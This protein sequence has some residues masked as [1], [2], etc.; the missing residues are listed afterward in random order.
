MEIIEGGGGEK[1]QERRSKEEAMEKIDPREK[2]KKSHRENL[3]GMEVYR[4]RKEK[5]T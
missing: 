4:F 2:E 3:V 1:L 5:K